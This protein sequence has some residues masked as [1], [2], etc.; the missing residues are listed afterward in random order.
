MRSAQVFKK[1]PPKILQIVVWQ[2]ESFGARNIIKG[3][4]IH[5][6]RMKVGHDKMA[7]GIV[8]V[9]VVGDVPEFVDAIG[10]ALGGPP[11][12]FVITPFAKAAGNGEAEAAGIS[13]IC[14]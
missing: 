2:P 12:P 4:R 7:V 8:A 14:K 1:T 3:G 11:R 13:M 9:T 10:C 6:F 5:F